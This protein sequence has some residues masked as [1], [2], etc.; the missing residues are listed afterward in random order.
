MSN[1][2]NG[3]SARQGKQMADKNRTRG[4]DEHKHDKMTQAIMAYFHGLKNVSL[5]RHKRIVFDRTSGKLLLVS[6]DE[7]NAGQTDRDKYIVNLPD[8]L[9]TIEG[10]QYVVELDG[11][12]H[13]ICDCEESESKQTKRRNDNYE[14]AGL[15]S[16]I[17]NEQLCDEFGVK[18]EDYF[19]LRLFEEAMKAR[20]HKRNME[21]GSSL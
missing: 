7:S 16:I 15:R 18:Y 4:S 13:G 5:L 14:K 12:T 11:K 3:Y 2:P 17:I 19:T 8:F 10:L 21:N 9:G 1:M 6:N 20:A